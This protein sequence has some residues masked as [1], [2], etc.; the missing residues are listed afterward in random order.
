MLSAKQETELPYTASGTIGGKLEIR[1]AATAREILVQVDMLHKAGVFPV[2][3]KKDGVLIGSPEAI[4]SL[5]LE[6]ARK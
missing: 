6:E 2:H 4:E 3:I 1:K 5:I